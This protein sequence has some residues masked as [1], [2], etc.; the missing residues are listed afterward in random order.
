[1][2]SMRPLRRRLRTMLE[3]II[4]LRSACQPISAT[5]VCK[6]EMKTEA[7]RQRLTGR[8]RPRGP[9]NW[10]GLKALLTG[11]QRPKGPAQYRKAERP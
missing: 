8:Q 10:N 7:N 11:R 1:M 3:I 5:L 6:T 9:A 2:S 4:T